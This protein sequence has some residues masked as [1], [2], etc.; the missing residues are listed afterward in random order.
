MLSLQQRASCMFCWI[1]ANSAGR[2]FLDGFQKCKNKHFVM[3]WW[4]SYC[5]E[6]ISFTSHKCTP[7]HLLAFSSSFASFFLFV[8][9]K[10]YSLLIGTVLLRA[11]PEII[12]LTAEIGKMYTSKTKLAG[13]SLLAAWGHEICH[14]ECVRVSTPSSYITKDLFLSQGSHFILLYTSTSKLRTSKLPYVKSKA[15]FSRKAQHS[16]LTHGSPDK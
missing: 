5:Q 7:L 13:K 6:H 4:Q 10:F 1:V 8:F 16:S 14:G 12:L 11:V 15:A 2:L 3:K 9:G